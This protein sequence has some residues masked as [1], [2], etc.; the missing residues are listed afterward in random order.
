[1]VKIKKTWETV[2]FTASK[3][4]LKP[5]TIEVSINHETGKYKL[6]TGSEESVSFEN[7]TIEVSKLKIEAIKEAI[8]Y[9]ENLN[10]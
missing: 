5:V 7:D 9:I 2:F 4:G 6:C 3:K 10:L 1:M 8:K